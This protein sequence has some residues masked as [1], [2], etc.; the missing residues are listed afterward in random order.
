MRKA[1]IWIAVASIAVVCAAL[2]LRSVYNGGNSIE[3][4]ALTQDMDVRRQVPISGVQVTAVV[5]QNVIHGTSD[6][7]GAFRLPL[8][9]AVWLR[10]TVELQ[11][12]HPGYKPLNLS[13][14]LTNEIYVVRMVAT[15]VSSAGGVSNAQ[16]ALKDVRL[17]YA[18]KATTPMNVGSVAKAFEVVNKGNVPCDGAAVCSPDGQWKAAIG[19]VTLDA[20]EGNEFRN[21]RT[22]CIAGPCPFTRIESDQASGGGRIIKVSARDWSDTVTF[23]VEAEVIQTRRSDLILNAYPAIFGR[24]MSFTLPPAAEGPSI[25]A[26]TNGSEIVYPLGP[27][28]TLS[29]ALCQLRV[30]SDGTKLYRCELKP[31]YEFQ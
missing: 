30:G 28:L 11:F 10:E 17:R 2:I 31:G 16:T 25:E 14:R 3:G 18:T 13:Q 20:G 29:W 7:T 24:E 23:L 8:T 15:N 6:A 26:V 5:G 19:G 1:T 27:A 22:S 12:R 21:V 4:V 9:G